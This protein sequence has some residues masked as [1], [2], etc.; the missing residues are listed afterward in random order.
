MMNKS[1]IIAHKWL[2]QRG[3]SNIIFHPNTTPD[4]ATDQGDF[5]VKTL[6]SRGITFTVTQLRHLK[7]NANTI[8]L[9][10]NDTDIIS[11]FPFSNIQDRLHWNGLTIRRQAQPVRLNAK[12]IFRLEAFRMHRRATIDDLVNF[13][14]DKAETKR[15]AKQ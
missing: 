15:G 10:A 1:E 11:H 13:V 9:V 3:Y 2:N 8:I 12:T 4:F 14:L 7:Q 6:A 5:E